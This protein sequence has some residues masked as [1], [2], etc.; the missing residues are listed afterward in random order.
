MTP[1]LA[2]ILSS[3][4]QGVQKP[5]GVALQARNSLRPLAPVSVLGLVLQPGS[6][7]SSTV[8]RFLNTISA[9]GRIWRSSDCQASEIRNL[10]ASGAASQSEASL[11]F[12]YLNDKN[13]RQ[14]VRQNFRESNP[15]DPGSRSRLHRKPRRP[16]NSGTEI[17]THP[18]FDRLHPNHESGRTARWPNRSPN[19]AVS[20]SSRNPQE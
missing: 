5:I 7:C 1:T 18:F 13:A 14:L 6:N 3:L 16:S 11:E 17:P 8:T 12:R 10:R 2:N 4:L 20:A 19:S 9:A 15:A